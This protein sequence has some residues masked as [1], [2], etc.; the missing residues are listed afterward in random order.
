MVQLP[1][2]RCLH[3]LNGK[4][5]LRDHHV[6]VSRLHSRNEASKVE[7]VVIFGSAAFFLLAFFAQHHWETT[8]TVK[9]FTLLLAGCEICLAELVRRRSPLSRLTIA[10]YAA[11]SVIMTVIATF[12]AL[13]QR[14]IMPALAAEMVALGWIGLRLNFPVLRRGAYLVG[15]VVLFR[16]VDDIV[17]RLEPFERFVPVFNGRFLVCAV[18]VTGFYL[19]LCFLS[20][21]RDKLSTKERYAIVATFVLTQ[22]LSLAVLSVE[23]HDFFR[24]RSPGHFFDWGALSAFPL[25]PLGAVCVSLDDSGDL[26]EDSGRPCP[27]NPAV[28][29]NGVEGVP[30]RPVRSA[31]LLSHHLIHRARP[32]VAGGFLWL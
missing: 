7:Q 12:V 1:P 29:R 13:E 31:N 17:L 2:S 15:L 9:I 23:V 19:L 21:C 6:I 20:R 8:W 4:S 18:A 30:G 28:R 10:A 11:V 32:V 3:C 16:F 14:W 26:Q 25:G 24:F 27:G 5:F 22:A